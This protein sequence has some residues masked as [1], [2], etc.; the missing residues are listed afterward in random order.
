MVGESKPFAPNDPPP[1]F[2]LTYGLHRRLAYLR[3]SP[4]TLP[5]NEDFMK[6]TIG[7]GVRTS[8]GGA[9]T[10]DAHEEKVRI[11]SV[12]TMF[13]IDSIDSTVARNKTGEPEQL[14]IL[15]TTADIS[16]RELAK[17]LEI[18]LLPKRKV[19]ETEAEE[20]TDDDSAQT[21]DSSDE[22]TDS[23]EEAPVSKGKEK[24]QWQSATDVPDEVF[25]QAKVIEATALPSE[26]AQD[27]QHAF[28]V[29]VETEG[30]LYV[31]VRKGIRAHGNYPLAE[32][33][34]AVVDV[35]RLPRE[36]QIEGQG[37]LLALNGERKFSVRSR[38][39]NA[40][41]Y[42]IARVGTTQINHLVSQ[43]E[44]KFR[45]SEISGSRALQP[46]KHFA[47]CPRTSTDRAG[48][49]MESEL[50]G[51]RFLG[52]ISQTLRW[53]QRARAVLSDRARVGPGRQKGDQID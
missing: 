34:N 50:L 5:E 7:K 18:R 38:G 35:P 41:E 19:A 1:H 51:V 53:R 21:S 11:P 45:K 31:R 3:S 37:G 26:K 52:A 23:S 36:V 28:R 25:D 12:A 32:D 43:T 9:Q 14:L 46:G 4:I 47:H 20:T 15:T 16:T 22:E 29:R 2:A 40:I 10:K 49:P 33:Y 30:E 48:K 13:R 42:E 8:Q 17:A 39:L 27:R 24:E 44:G 6:L